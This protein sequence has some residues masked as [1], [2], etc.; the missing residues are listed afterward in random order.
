MER[1]YLYV[2]NGCGVARKGAGG[3]LSGLSLGELRKGWELGG[4]F[5]LRRS[6]VLWMW[7]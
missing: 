5:E 4:A 1:A 6:L 7:V 2:R 3:Q